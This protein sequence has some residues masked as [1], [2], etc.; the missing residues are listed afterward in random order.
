MSVICRLPRI[1]GSYSLTD[2]YSL[3]LCQITC[4][5]PLWIRNIFG[6]HSYIKIVWLQKKSLFSYKTG[7]NG[8]NLTIKCFCKT[9]FV[10]KTSNNQYPKNAV[11]W[12]PVYFSL[13]VHNFDNSFKTLA[14]ISIHWM[15]KIEVERK[16]FKIFADLLWYGIKLHMFKYML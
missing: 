13:Q 4:Y 14:F 8:K 11:E 7:K 2:M 3:R 1:A 12:N 10:F 9:S 15:D 6:F 16:I 5:H